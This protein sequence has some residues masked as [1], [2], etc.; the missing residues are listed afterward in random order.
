MSKVHR[1]NV[2]QN[3]ASVRRRLSVSCSLLYQRV[4]RITI[5]TFHAAKQP[6]SNRMYVTVLGLKFIPVFLSTNQILPPRVPWWD[7]HC[8]T[9]DRYYLTSLEFSLQIQPRANKKA[10]LFGLFTLCYNAVSILTLVLKKNQIYFWPAVGWIVSSIMKGTALCCVCSFEKASSIVF[11]P[12]SYSNSI[13]APNN[14]H[15]LVH[16]HY[17]QFY[18]RKTP[19]SLYEHFSLEIFA[20]RGFDNVFLPS[21]SCIL[22]EDS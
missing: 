19:P 1:S 18:L 16:H 12:I 2:S 7:I 8:R 3:W 22:V 11:N 14:R 10:L 15:D 21:S 17:F 20:Q 4:S 5:K 13:N 6:P 9:C